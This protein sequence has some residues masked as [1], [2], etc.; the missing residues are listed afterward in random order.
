MDELRRRRQVARRHQHAGD[1]QFLYRVGVGA[2]RIEHRHAALAHRLY[3]NVVG[4]GAGARNGLDR[5]GDL[6]AVQ[7]GGTQQDRIGLRARLVDFVQ[8]LR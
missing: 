7:V 5:V 1:D 4:T 3:R 8:F 6:G 2:R